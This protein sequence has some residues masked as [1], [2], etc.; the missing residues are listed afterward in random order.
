MN[1]NVLAHSFGGNIIQQRESDGFIN[2]TGMC[3]ATGKQWNDFFRLD[4]SKAFLS[5]LS[6]VTGYPVTALYQV[7]QGGNN[8]N[9]QGTWVHP[10]FAIN[11]ATWCSA[12]F[13]VQVSKWVVE[14]F[15]TAQNPIRRGEPV[16]PTLKKMETLLAL[17][18]RH[19]VEALKYAHDIC[20]TGVGQKGGNSTEDGA[21]HRSYSAE[22]IAETT[23]DRPRRRNR[24]KDLAWAEILD[25]LDKYGKT[26][27]L[28]TKKLLVEFREAYNTRLLGLPAWVLDAVPSFGMS[29]LNRR[30]A[31]RRGGSE[32]LGRKRT[33]EQDAPQ[34]LIF[35][36]NLL[37]DCPRMGPSDVFRAVQKQFPTCKLPSLRT[38]QRLVNERVGARKFYL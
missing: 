10:Y 9:S 30:R 36:D 24:P 28:P 2:A 4:S 18:D 15:Q 26:H 29:T 8:Q 25:A 7:F 3:K 19:G 5:E 31:E 21:G 34:V 12:A 13:A 23:V 17:A 6:T 33:L 22:E 1:N 32:R 35:V 27:N 14:W 11:L 16:D 37:V 38:F 20:G